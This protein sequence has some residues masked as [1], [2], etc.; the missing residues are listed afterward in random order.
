MQVNR[1]T[2]ARTFWQAKTAVEQDLRKV[3]AV[4]VLAEITRHGQSRSLAAE[5]E[6][7][8]WVGL[9]H[10]TRCHR[11][12]GQS[13]WEVHDQGRACAPARQFGIGRTHRS[14]KGD[15][16]LSLPPRASSVVVDFQ[17]N[18]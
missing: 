9:G 11:V 16:G 1:S 4:H 5:P 3:M 12:L 10:V 18:A 2:G 15:V 7:L 17:H 6:D 13:Q 8:S 14:S